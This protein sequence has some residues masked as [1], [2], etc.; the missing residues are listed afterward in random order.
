MNLFPGGLCVVALAPL[1]LAADNPPADLLNRMAAKVIQNQGLIHNYTCVET[2]DRE[3]Y[4]PAASTLPHECQLLLEERKHPSLVM[5]LR[6]VST[7]RLRLEVATTSGG[8]IFSW[9]GASKFEDQSIYDLVR[10]GPI[11]TGAHGA[12]LG[13]VLQQDAHSFI[14]EGEVVRS[15][16]RLAAYSFTVPA[17]DSHYFVQLPEKSGRIISA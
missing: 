16:R 12:F 9:P 6:L 3:F 14:Y 4:Q 10:D 11:A 13:V 15:G 2:V 7:D 5:E 8:E 17:R 1:L